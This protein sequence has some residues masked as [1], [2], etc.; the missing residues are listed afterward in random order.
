M[1]ALLAIVPFEALLH[2]TT[3]VLNPSFGASSRLVGG[4]DADLIT[5]DLLVEIKTRQQAKVEAGDL[6]QLLAYFLLARRERLADASFPAINRVGVYFS[7][8]GHLWKFDTAIWTAHAQ[9]PELEEW[10]F[11][12]AKELL[13]TKFPAAT[14][15]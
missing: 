1:L 14:P 11:V 15:R 12:R 2:P 7:R 6:D 9:F 3:L 4:A 5:G 13:R 10:F 8:H